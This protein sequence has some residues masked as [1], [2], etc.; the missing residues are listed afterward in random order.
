MLAVVQMLVDFIIGKWPNQKQL[1]ARKTGHSRAFPAAVR[2]KRDRA[3]SA[4]QPGVYR[5]VS[6]LHLPW[7]SSSASMSCRLSQSSFLAFVK[8]KRDP[9]HGWPRDMAKHAA[10]RGPFCRVCSVSSDHSKRYETVCCGLRP[11]PV[12]LSASSPETRWR[13][14]HDTG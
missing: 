5:N 6:F 7:T 14:S 9:S 2:S 10:P 4:G 8:C 1:K 13:H 3:S 12:N 11:W